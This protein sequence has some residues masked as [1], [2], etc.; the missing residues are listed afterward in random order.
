[1]SGD[2]LSTETPNPIQPPPVVIPPPVWPLP[3]PHYLAPPQQEAR[4]QYHNRIYAY[5]LIGL[6][7]FYAVGTIMIV[8][9]F[10][11][12]ATEVPSF[13]IRFVTCFYGIVIAMI[14]W[15]MILRKAA[16]RAGRVATFVLNIFLLPL[17]PLG[18]AVGVYGL[19]KVDKRDR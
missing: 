9:V 5:L 14:I 7:C 1:M 8:V 18:T 11:L 6:A 17:F 16:P 4:A 15:T 19:W 10:S 3:Q 13:V 12:N 2:Y